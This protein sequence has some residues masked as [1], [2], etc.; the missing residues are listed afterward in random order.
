VRMRASADSAF[1][2][3]QV[4]THAQTKRVHYLSSDTVFDFA[5]SVCARAEIFINHENVYRLSQHCHMSCT[6]Q[7]IV[8]THRPVRNVQLSEHH[9][10]NQG[11]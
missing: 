8:Y 11:K 6:S 1:A 5:S 3:F 10:M 7:R 9:K 4:V 2:W